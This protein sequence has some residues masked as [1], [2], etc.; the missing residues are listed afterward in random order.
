MTSHRIG[1]REEW[2]AASAE[3]LAREKSLRGWAISSPGSGG[4]LPWVPVG[5]E[6][7]APDRRRGQDAGRAV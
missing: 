7:T 2:L 1:P 4:E 5:K 6:Y 3:L